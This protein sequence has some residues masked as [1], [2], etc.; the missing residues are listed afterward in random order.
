MVGFGSSWGLTLC[1]LAVAVKISTIDNL[2]R[3][4]FNSESIVETCN[5]SGK[6]PEYIHLFIHCEIGAST[7]R[8][9]LSR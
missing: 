7:W 6:D 3:K 8:D 2:R 9:L 1:W 5:M 4:S